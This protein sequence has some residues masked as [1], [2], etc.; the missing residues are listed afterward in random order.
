MVPDEFLGRKLVQG[1]YPAVKIQRNVNPFF[2]N[3]TRPQTSRQDYVIYVGR[4]I[5]QKGV[6][7]L[8]R[9]MSLVRSKVRLVL[10]GQGEL[11][12]EIQSVI[13]QLGLKNKVLLEGPQWG[14]AVE[15]LIIGASAVIIPSEWYDNL[16]LILCQANALGKPVIASR[17]DGIPEYI[18]DGQNGYL[19]TPGDPVELAGCID[20][21][22]TLSNKV[23]NS[24]SL[25]SRNVAEKEFDY[26]VHY[27][28]I[29]ELIDLI[30]RK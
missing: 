27:K 21:V 1:G 3:P 7:T 2:V 22:M 23:Y 26:P 5:R 13:D 18:R 10:V 25:S 30:L 28:K 14:E 16:P 11:E 4:F 20:R 19:F 29:I 9:A 8:L 17:I 24:L 6:L 15:Y 12:G